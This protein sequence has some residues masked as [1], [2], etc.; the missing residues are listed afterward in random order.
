[1]REKEVD[2]S[3]RRGTKQKSNGFVLPSSN[4]NHYGWKGSAGVNAVLINNQEN[5]ARA[6]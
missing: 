5:F 3:E 2:E 6:K 4:Q 1:M